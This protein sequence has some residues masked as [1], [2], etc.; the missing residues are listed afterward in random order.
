MRLDMESVQNEKSAIEKLCYEGHKNI[1]KVIQ[2]S[3]FAD[4]S[5]AF[6]DMELCDLN[7]EEYNRCTWTMIQAAHWIPPGFREL[8][9]WNIMKQIA[10][11][12]AFIHNHRLVHRDLKLRNGT[13]FPNYSRLIIQSPLLTKR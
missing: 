3:E 2:V 4:K 9:V 5:Y 6:I 11:G 7:L 1:V 13:S 12:L 10:A 8:E